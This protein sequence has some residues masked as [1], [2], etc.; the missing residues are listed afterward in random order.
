MSCKRYVDLGGS[1]GAPG[2]GETTRLQRMTA[3]LKHRSSVAVRGPGRA[4]TSGDGLRDQ[5]RWDAAGAKRIEELTSDPGR[6]LVDESPHA[7]KVF[8]ADLM[9]SLGSLSRLEILELGC[10]RG[11]LAVYLATQGATVTGIDIGE[12]LIRA[13][14]L[15]AEIN[16]VDCSFVRAS[17]TELPFEERTFDRVVGVA[18]L[19]HL[20]KEDLAQALRET[21]RVLKP[22]GTALFCEPIEN[23]RVF[24]FIQSLV[25]AGRPGD[26]DY[27]PS[28]LR[29]RAWAEYRR[30]QDQRALTVRELREVG[31]RFRDV[32][33]IRH[34]GILSRLWRLL[35]RRS[36][37]PLEAV[38]AVLLRRLP[39]LR[40]LARSVLIEYAVAP[41]GERE[42][43]P[44]PAD[45]LHDRAVVRGLR[46]PSPPRTR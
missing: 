25:P 40:Y 10:G 35:G 31:A 27:R 17:A 24:D 16:D 45:H 6:F 46:A 14:R 41:E 18:V 2:A 38:D 22:S 20:S 29:R 3:A 33:I 44:T 1:L 21:Q 9:A 13:A 28:I 19:H 11:E 42:P 34:Y 32:T 5:S 12:T 8:H 30:G 36:R 37:A 4:A 39:P 26:A 15:L 7:R 23:S 43:A